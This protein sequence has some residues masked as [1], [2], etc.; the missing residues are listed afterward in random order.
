MKF[1]S[2]HKLDFLAAPYSR[3]FTEADEPPWQEFK[4][5][6]CFGLWRANK[7][8]YEILSFKN[9]ESGNGHLEDVF[10]WFEQSCKRDKYNLVVI[11]V[12]NKRFE[13][14]LIEKRG[15]E[16]FK[17]ENNSLIKRL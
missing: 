12:W 4:I 9:K 1:Q 11:E 10:E 8:N 14:H 3:Q 15:F 5:G 13:K 17:K 2:T 16:V 7:Q 6:T